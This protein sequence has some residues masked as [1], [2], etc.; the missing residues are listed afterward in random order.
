MKTLQFIT[1]QTDRHS[2]LDGALLALKGG[3]R[4]IQLRMKGA[5]REQILKEG[6]PLRELCD[7]YQATMILDDHV[8]L[9]N[10]LGADG[11]HLGQKDMPIADARALLGEKYIIG[12]TANTLAEIRRHYEHGANYVGCGPF[13]F[14]TTK[15]QLAPTLGLE[16]YRMLLKEMKEE[17]MEL[18]L[19]AIGGITRED[20]RPLIELGV[21]GIALSS[22][23]LCAA[24]P[25]EEVKK[26]LNEIKQL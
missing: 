14:T 2:Y 25:T 16:G 20:I 7:E 4:W 9:V 6:R 18:P 17:G 22:T 3:C 24:D 15:E 8:E 12:G 10:E 11:V 21:S 5:T 19:V 1:H 26:I 23:V 13:R